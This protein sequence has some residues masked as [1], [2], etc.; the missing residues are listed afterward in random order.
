MAQPGSLFSKYSF[1]RLDSDLMSHK[2]HREEAEA[3]MQHLTN[4]AQQTSELYHE[5]HTLDR[6]EQDYRRKLQEE[7]TLRVGRRG[8][9]LMILHS[10][11]KRQRKLVK[12]LKKKS[13]WSKNL[14][15]VV[16]KL[17]DIVTYLHQE[18]LDAF[19]N[20]GADVLSKKNPQRLGVSGLALHYA[21][22]INQIDSI[23]SR[24]SC[25]P[26]NTR[27]M[28]YHGL[29]SSV[30]ASLRSQLHTFHSKEQLTASQIKAEMEKTLQWIVP[31]A[32]NTTK[33]HQ[34]FGWV[35]EWAN[36]GNEFHKKT[37]TQGSLIRLQTLHHADKEKTDKYILELVTWLHRLVN[38]VRYR[39]HGFKPILSSNHKC[40]SLLPQTVKDVAQVHDGETVKVLQLSQEDR[41]MLKEVTYRRLVPG[42][43]KSQEFISRKKKCN[44][45][46]GLSRSSG[47]SPT[48]ELRASS[49][50]SNE[51]VN[52]LDVMD[53]LDTL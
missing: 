4:L 10:E 3:T 49:D 13:L 38:Q 15:E 33:A 52:V 20:I 32:T 36:T 11:L 18:I 14:E 8:E 24:P 2:L 23:V 9:T 50:L 40:V 1:D 53:G 19:G 35:G 12:S 39:D 7:E 43:S 51:R 22:I 42:I 44:R 6:F 31:V 47:N 30:K 17:V 48:K 34:G 41:Q 5:L 25:I 26:P 28:L 16:E 29:P 45:H 27:D 37:V 21:N 46:W